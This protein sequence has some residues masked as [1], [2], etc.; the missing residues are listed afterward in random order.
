MPESRTLNRRRVY[1]GEGLRFDVTSDGA[2]LETE[3][4][5]LTSAGIGLAVLSAP[6]LPGVGEAVTV[7]Y[8]G[9]GGPAAPQAAM[10]RHVGCLRRGDRVLPRLGVSFVPAPVAIGAQRWRCPDA[11][12][13]FAT[14][15]CSWFFRER[16]RL[17]VLDA[18]ADGMTL[19]AAGPHVPLLPGAE[20][21]LEVHLPYAGCEPARGRL[22]AAGR[23]AVRI[24][25]IEPSRAL[26]GALAQYLLAT[27]DTLTPAALRA[28]GLRAGSIERVVSYDYA[29]TEADYEA[30]LAL[31]LRAHQD[32]GHLEGVT[33]ADMRSAYD[34][35][36]RH[37]TCRFGGRIVGYVRV[38]FVDGAAARSQYVS[39]GGHQVPQWLWDAG[40]VEAGAGAI[41]PAFQRA[42]LFVPL[43]QHSVRVAVQSGHRYVLGACDDDLL[44]MYR[45]MGFELLETR[46]VEP[47]PGWRFRSHLIYLDA[48]RLVDEPPA[49]PTVARMAAAIG[50][51]GLGEDVV[52]RAA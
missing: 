11:L 28:G 37:L 25:W 46:L 7:G 49:T 40:F 17:R 16:A 47:K 13:A 2:V 39:M 51:A 33:V 23:E 1:L 6:V 32:E 44:G 34:A 27:D 14:A 30:V 31:R 50:F 48:A 43:M 9:P 45:E 38:I 21:E 20:V 36:S 41:E 12:P 24:E 15:T 4:I 18:G 5:D 29:A 26:L 42:G 35:H 3:A 22:V 52:E 10:V 8:A 19:R